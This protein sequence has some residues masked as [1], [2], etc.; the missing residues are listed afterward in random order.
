MKRWNKQLRWV[1]FLVGLPVVGYLVLFLFT[2]VCGKVVG[3]GDQQPPARVIH[4][5]GGWAPE[6]ADAIRRLAKLHF[7]NHPRLIERYWPDPSWIEERSNCWVVGFSPKALVYDFLG[8][9]R[10]VRPT[11]Q[12]MYFTIEKADFRTRFGIWY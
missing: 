10:V 8:Y 4:L 5:P 3:A 1:A 6:D 7:D 9:R 12:R 2:P 11:D